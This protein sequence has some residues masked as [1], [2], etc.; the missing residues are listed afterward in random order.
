MNAVTFTWKTNEWRTDKYNLFDC[1]II[2][3]K[4]D[5]YISNFFSVYKFWEDSKEIYLQ[6]H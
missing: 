5:N 4:G 3:V 2:N 1:I 6:L